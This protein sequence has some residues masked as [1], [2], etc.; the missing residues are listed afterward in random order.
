MQLVDFA[1]DFSWKWLCANDQFVCGRSGEHGL[2]RKQH[3]ELVDEWSDKHFHH[4]GDVHVHVSERLDKRKPNG[5]DHLHADRNRRRRLNHIYSDRYGKQATD[6]NGQLLHCK[7][8]DDHFR[9]QQYAEL[10]D[11]RS[12]KHCHHAG[13]IHVHIGK[14]LNKR[15]PNGNDHLHADSN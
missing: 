13:D 9:W 3:A 7:P 6:T 14:R 11:Q 10:V 15:E 4:A 1:D 12:D 5:D 2:W 8:R